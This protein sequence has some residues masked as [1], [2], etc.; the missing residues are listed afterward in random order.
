MS[1]LLIAILS[2]SKDRQFSY[3]VFL[4]GEK[5]GLGMGKT[6]KDTQQ[7]A[8][9]NALHTLAAELLPESTNTVLLYS[10]IYNIFCHV[11]L[12]VC[13]VYFLICVIFVHMFNVRLMFLSI[14][15]NIVT[16]SRSCQ[17]VNCTTLCL[18]LSICVPPHCAA[19]LK[20][21][22]QRAK[23]SPTAF[24]NLWSSWIIKKKII[25]A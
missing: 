17:I 22:T 4:T 8:A 9:K 14:M 16:K 2:S 1:E 12:Y 7:Q 23:Y 25:L 18:P 5:V 11:L 13:V 20:S 6:R 19:W 21:V 10:P 3:E 15:S 24:I